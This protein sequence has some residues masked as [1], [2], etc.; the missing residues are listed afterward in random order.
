MGVQ[1]PGDQLMSA[2]TTA[3]TTAAHHGSFLTSPMLIILAVFLLFYVWM[4]RQ[5]GKKNK[6]TKDLLAKLNKGD[7]VVTAG[8]I[9]GKIKNIAEEMVT[10]QVGKESHLTVSRSSISSLLPKGTVKHEHN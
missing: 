5:Q 4:F 8:G 1:Q 7:E 2:T 9:M 6:K 10:L 3:A